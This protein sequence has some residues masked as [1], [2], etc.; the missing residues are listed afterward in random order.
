MSSSSEQ[1]KELRNQ[2]ERSFLQH[3]NLNL[4]ALGKL[5]LM[6]EQQE[7]QIENLIAE[8]WKLKFK[9]EELE[10]DTRP[11]NDL[12][13]AMGISSVSKSKYISEH[14]NMPLD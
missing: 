13:R 8:N 14:P 9:I 6:A 4:T 10:E 12:D 1:V 2:I 11:A 5:C 7:K 3:G